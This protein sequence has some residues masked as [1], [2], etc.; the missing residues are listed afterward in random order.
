[1]KSCAVTN[2]NC[3]VE[4]RGGEQW[5]VN[6]QSVTP[7]ARGGRPCELDSVGEDGRACER[8]AKPVVEGP[9]SGIQGAAWSNPPPPSDI[10]QMV[11]DGMVGRPSTGIREIGLGIPVFMPPGGRRAAQDEVRAPIVARKRV[12]IVERREG[13]EMEGNWCRRQTP[14][15]CE[16]PLG[17]AA[18]ESAPWLTL[19]DAPRPWRP[20][21]GRALSH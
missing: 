2:H 4:T 15:R 20:R 10:P 17:C 9:P 19:S 11:G 21:L 14:P 18:E 8:R 12:M 5:N 16:C 3:V 1:M 6:G 7:S 13:R